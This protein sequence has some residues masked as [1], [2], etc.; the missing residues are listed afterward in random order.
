MLT[1]RSPHDAYRR[2]E[3][4]ARVIGASSDQ[5]VLVCYEQLGAALARALH[6]AAAG[7]NREKSAALTRALTAIAAL[8]MG[9]DPVAGIAPVLGQFY[10]AARAAVLDCAIEFRPEV[11]TRL[12]ADFAEIARSFAA[13]G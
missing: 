6:A 11:L 3:F 8:Q 12:R 1:Q 13:A 2:V 10:G 5:L 4:D 9:I 7:D